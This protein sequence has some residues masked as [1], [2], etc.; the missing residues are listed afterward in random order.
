M[1]FFLEDIAITTCIVLMRR[2]FSCL[3]HKQDASYLH[4]LSVCLPI[5]HPVFLS[6]ILSSYLSFFGPVASLS[7]FLSILRPD[8]CLVCHFFPLHLTV[9]CHAKD[10]LF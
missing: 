10:L 6:V 1:L 2:G 3:P 8:P 5:C 7:V 9:L 4:R